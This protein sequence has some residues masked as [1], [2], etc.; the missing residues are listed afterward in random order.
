MLND[1]HAYTRSRLDV[2][3]APAEGLRKL[4]I[5]LKYLFNV[6]RFIMFSFTNIGFYV[7]KLNEVVAI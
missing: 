5:S 1:V 4:N 2:R 7:D 3:G 6:E